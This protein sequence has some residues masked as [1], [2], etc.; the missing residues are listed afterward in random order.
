LF[1]DFGVN[2]GLKVYL[3]KPHLTEH[4]RNLTARIDPDMAFRYA[5][6]KQLLLQEFKLSSF[7][8]YDSRLESVLSYYVESR[9]VEDYDS[10]TDFLDL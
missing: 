3:L 6:V 4:A 9:K 7:N 10:L 8:L 1:A 5:D 2:D